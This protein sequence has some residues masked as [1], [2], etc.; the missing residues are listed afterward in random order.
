MKTS[1]ENWWNDTDRE[2]QKYWERNLTQCHFVQNK[3]DIDWPG[4]EPAPSGQS[5]DGTDRL[6]RK[7]NEG[8]PLHVEEQPRRAQI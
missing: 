2:R 8:L 5:G 6:F 7:L 4:I 1:V 3:P